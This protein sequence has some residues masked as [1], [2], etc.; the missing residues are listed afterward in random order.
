[1][2]LTLLQDETTLRTETRSFKGDDYQVPF[3][4]VAGNKVW[5]ATAMILAEFLALAEEAED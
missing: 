5:G 2:P 4:D 1:M 3:F